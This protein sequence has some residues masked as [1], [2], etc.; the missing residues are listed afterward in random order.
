M[1]AEG[2]EAEYHQPRHQSWNHEQPA[3]E[4]VG[5]KRSA[6]EAVSSD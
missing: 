3:A 6:K 4:N 2:V 5:I 1:R